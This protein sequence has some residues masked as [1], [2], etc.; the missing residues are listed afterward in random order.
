[1]IRDLRIHTGST[2]FS[3]VVRLQRQVPRHKFNTSNSTSL[4]ARAAPAQREIYSPSIFREV[5]L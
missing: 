1:M 2:I 4:Q 5:I 3:S